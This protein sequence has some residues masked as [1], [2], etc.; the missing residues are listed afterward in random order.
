MDDNSDSEENGWQK[1]MEMDGQEINKK[2]KY[3]NQIMCRQ[4]KNDYFNRKLRRHKL[5]D[6]HNPR[7]FK[8]S[9]NWRPAEQSS[10]GILNKKEIF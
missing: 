8:K 6:I 2:M 10:Q 5:H 3:K 4:A 1:E 7:M 9:K